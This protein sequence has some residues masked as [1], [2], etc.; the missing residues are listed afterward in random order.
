MIL[1]RIRDLFGTY[2]SLI[3]VTV[4]DEEEFTICGDVHG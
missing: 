3:N 4:P 1:L 2:P